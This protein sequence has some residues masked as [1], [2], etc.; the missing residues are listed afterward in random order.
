L[1]AV[2][3][4]GA[5]RRHRGE[6]NPGEPVTILFIPNCRNPQL[7]AGSFGKRLNLGKQERENGGKEVRPPRQRLPK[8]Q[9]RYNPFR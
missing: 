7:S 5:E 6:S 4:S 1:E 9:D 8:S 3:G 2:E